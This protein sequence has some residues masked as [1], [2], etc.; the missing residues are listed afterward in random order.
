MKIGFCQICLLL[1]IGLSAIVLYADVEYSDN[2]TWNYTIVD[3]SAFLYGVS[4]PTPVTS[5]N[6]VLHIPSMLGGYPVVE[7]E[8]GIHPD[9]H[10]ELV[11][12]ASVTS[13]RHNSLGGS[14]DDF[15]S[16]FTNRLERITVEDGNPRYMSIDGCLYS[17]DGKT[18]I[19]CPAGY[20]GKVVVADGVKFIADCAFLGCSEV[21]EIRLP[22]SLV[23]IGNKGLSCSRREGVSYNYLSCLTNINIPAS[24]RYIGDNAFYCCGELNIDAVIPD[25]VQRIGAYAFYDCKGIRSLDLPDS[26]VDIGPDA[27]Y[28]CSQIK[29]ATMRGNLRIIEPRAFYGCTNMRLNELPTSLIFCAEDAFDGV[30]FCPGMRTISKGAFTDDSS[31]QQLE[32]PSSVETISPS[33]FYSFNSLTSVRIPSSVKYIGHS[34]FQYCR[35]LTDVT[36]EEGVEEIA[37][38]AFDQ[39]GATS[40]TIPES[41]RKIGYYSRDSSNCVNIYSSSNSDYKNHARLIFK[42][43]PPE[44]FSES[45]VSLYV[46]VYFTKKYSAEWEAVLPPT[47]SKYG[48]TID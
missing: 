27:F 8:G 45:K 21:T 12:P 39:I 1:S 13:I 33:A 40:L 16:R 37:Y 36:I 25:G 28:G 26:L 3:S 34:A 31:I 22:D 7:I 30:P 11:I 41:V 10:T 44:G 38:M 47:S 24:I 4:S 6:D 46:D 19:K 14:G 5:T 2:E 17:K 32:I 9:W 18:F 20:K 43:L 35:N 15:Y 42:G 29:Q 48:G 23:S